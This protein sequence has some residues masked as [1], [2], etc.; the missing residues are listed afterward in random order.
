MRRRPWFVALWAILASGLWA[1]HVA[2]GFPGGLIA[3]HSGKRSGIMGVLNSLTEVM[4]VA[5]LGRPLV[6]KAL[7]LAGVVAT[8]LVWRI[9]D[10]KRSAEG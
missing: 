8:V 9:S 3:A 10:R 5:P 1:Y 6:V 4:L 2:T 7:V